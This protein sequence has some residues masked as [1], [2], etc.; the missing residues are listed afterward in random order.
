MDAKLCN[1]QQELYQLEQE[2]DK[3]NHELE[4]N[5]DRKLYLQ[6]AKP[7]LQ[8]AAA[9][10]VTKVYPRHHFYMAMIMFICVIVFYMFLYLFVHYVI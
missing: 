7:D 8:H 3:V 4:E 2:L 10:T 9:E 5:A 6:F 1:R